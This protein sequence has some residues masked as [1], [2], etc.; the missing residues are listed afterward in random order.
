MILSIEKIYQDSDNTIHVE[1]VIE[2]FILVSEATLDSPEEYGPAICET[3]FELEE[4]EILPDNE[5]ELIDF[6]DKMYLEWKLVE[7]S[8]DAFDDILL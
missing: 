4:D 8:Y 6:L 1:A 7:C 5:N 2:D 3:S